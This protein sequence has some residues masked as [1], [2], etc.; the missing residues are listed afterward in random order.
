MP[1]IVDLAKDTTDVEFSW[2][3]EVVHLTFRTNAITPRHNRLIGRFQKIYQ[4]SLLTP[5]Q[6]EELGE[7]VSDDEAGVMTEELARMLSQWITSW[8]VVDGRK[9]YPITEDSMLDLPI[10][11]I[12]ALFSSIVGA[13]RPNPKS[14]EN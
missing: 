11:F 9:M 4:Q 2:E 10:A 13:N 5:E 12:F 14:V 7:L 1:K 3:G 8:D 6:R